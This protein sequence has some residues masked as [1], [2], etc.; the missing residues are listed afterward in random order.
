MI[1]RYPETVRTLAA[2]AAV[3]V[4]IALSAL[5]L[6]ALYIA[7]GTFWLSLVIIAILDDRRKR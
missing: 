1:K 4:L 6:P 3:G 2:I 5:W 7:V